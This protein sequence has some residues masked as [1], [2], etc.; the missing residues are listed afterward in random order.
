MSLYFV[1][2][3]FD[4]DANV[5]VYDKPG[6]IKQIKQWIEYDVDNPNKMQE[7]YIQTIDELEEG[8]PR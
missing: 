4:T 5:D 2:Y 7:E 8:N 3:Q 6:L 1:I